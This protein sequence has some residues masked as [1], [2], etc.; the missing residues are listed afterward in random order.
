MHDIQY[1]KNV[2]GGN[3]DI[4]FHRLYANNISLQSMTQD[5]R[6]SATSSHAVD[7]D[8]NNAYPQLLLNCATSFKLIQTSNFIYLNYIVVTIKLGD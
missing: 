5:A 7:I 3:N 8:I 2:L 6:Q 1:Y 4:V